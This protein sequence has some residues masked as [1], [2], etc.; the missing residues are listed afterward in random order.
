V[1]KTIDKNVELCQT[2]PKKVEYLHKL[3]DTTEHTQDN[4]GDVAVSQIPVPLKETTPKVV[5]VSSG[6]SS[7]FTVY[8]RELKII[9]M[10]GPESQKD[11]LSF[12]SLTHRVGEI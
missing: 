4:T 3:Q 11:R 2:I 9:G 7:Y 1:R 10:V 6:Q 8:R 5:T 12:V